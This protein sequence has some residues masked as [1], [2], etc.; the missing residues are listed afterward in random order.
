MLSP[1]LP[2]LNRCGCQQTSLYMSIS[3]YR[4]K[5]LVVLRECRCYIHVHSH[6][7]V[8]I[9]CHVSICNINST[10]HQ[11]CFSPLLMHAHSHVS[12][13]YKNSGCQI[14]L[15]I[16]HYTSNFQ[17]I[18]LAVTRYT[19]IKVIV[20]VK[21]QRNMQNKFPMNAYIIQSHFPSL[22]RK[23]IQDFTA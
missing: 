3:L 6:F 12:I 13:C 2:P 7:L 16:S 15:S 14:P 18:S 8:T 4:Y 20:F 9:C 23:N 19:H 1:E 21:S 17:F 22:G 11:M 5:T 10:T